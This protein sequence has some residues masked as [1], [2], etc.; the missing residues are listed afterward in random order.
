MF[1]VEQFKERRR[2]L[3]L[4]GSG[5]LSKL[6]HFRQRV[7]DSDTHSHSPHYGHTG[8]LTRSGQEHYGHT[9]TLTRYHKD[10]DHLYYGPV[11]N[12]QVRD[13]QGV[14]KACD[15]SVEIVKPKAMVQ[16]H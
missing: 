2:Q 3:E 15:W 9:G 10:A 12:L 4:P 6:T 5:L 16:W 11:K 7:S 8:T 13:D 1:N 14:K